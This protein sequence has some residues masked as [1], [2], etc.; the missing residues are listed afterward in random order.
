MPIVEPSTGKAPQID[1]GLY[2]VICKEIKE[3]TVDN[4]QFGNFDKLEVTLEFEDLLAPDGGPQTLEPRINKKWNEKATLFKWAVAFGLDV[5]PAE[6][7]D[8]DLLIDRK[9]QALVETAEEGGWPRV[10]KLTALPKKGGMAA[11]REAA[12]PKE[13]DGLTPSANDDEMIA[14]WKVTREMGVA[15]DKVLAIS[16][17][18]FGD[19]PGNLSAAEREQLLGLLK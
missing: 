10:T 16:Q 4:D 17:A 11:V 3:V 15:R 2:I 1:N 8:T 13:D 12:K 6:P 9:A 18:S 7:I 5:S 14:W 19:I